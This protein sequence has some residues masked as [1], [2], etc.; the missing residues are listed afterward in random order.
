MTVTSINLKPIITW[1][2]LRKS[3]RKSVKYCN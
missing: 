3:V 2:S 1:L